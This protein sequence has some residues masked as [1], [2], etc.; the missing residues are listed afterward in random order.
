MAGPGLH[1]LV[2]GGTGFIGA[3]LVQSLLRE[4]HRATILTRQTIA[5]TENCRHVDSLASISEDT[6][7][8]AVINLAGES[9]AGRR[10][11]SHYKQKISDSR[12]RTTKALV[13]CCTVLRGPCEISCP[14]MPASL[15]R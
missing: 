11:T 7:F 4:G 15:R 8:S 3:S 12:F 5:D 14:T 10:W 2:T 9:L 6:K 13:A 1:F